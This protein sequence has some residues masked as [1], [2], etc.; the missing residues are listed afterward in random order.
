MLGDLS[1]RQQ[2]AEDFQSKVRFLESNPVTRR[3]TAVRERRY[4][5]MNGADLN[6]SIR[7]VDGVEKLAAGLKRHGLAR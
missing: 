2:S 6:P 3:L 5:A 7:T 4:I 1:R